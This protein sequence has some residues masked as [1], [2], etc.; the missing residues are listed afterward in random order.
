MPMPIIMFRQSP[1][2]TEIIDG[3]FVMNPGSLGS[4]RGGNMLSYGV[5]TIDADGRIEMNII[6]VTAK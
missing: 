5:I 3:V 2:R 6:T 4:P 1:N